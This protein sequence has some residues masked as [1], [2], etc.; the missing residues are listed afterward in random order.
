M[1]Q[2]NQGYSEESFTPGLPSLLLLS[3]QV[4][5]YYWVL[6]LKLSGLLEDTKQPCSQALWTSNFHMR[7]SSSFGN[8]E[9]LSHFIYHLER[10]WYRVCWINTSACCWG[11]GTWELSLHIPISMDL[12]ISLEFV[13]RRIKERLQIFTT[14][15]CAWQWLINPPRAQ[16]FGQ[17]ILSVFVKMFLWTRLTFKY[18]DYSP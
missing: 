6:C 14:F 4:L 16:I 11:W 8:K 9:S 5:E 10:A 12:W 7:I 1:G 3:Y 2:T 18:V 13:A 17:T 15:L